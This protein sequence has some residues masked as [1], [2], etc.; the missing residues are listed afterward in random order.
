MPTVEKTFDGQFVWTDLSSD[1]VQESKEFY[2][3]VLDWKF[4]DESIGDEGIYSTGLVDG[5]PAGAIASQEPGQGETKWNVYFQTSDV[6]ATT[7]RVRTAG[8]T[9]VAEP[10]DVF[11]L[12]RMAIYKDP[13]GA[14]FCGWQPK[15]SKGFGVANEH[16]ANGWIELATRD[17]RVKDFY[18]KVFD[19]ELNEI[20]MGPEAKDPY[21]IF[22]KGENFV[23]GMATMTADWGDYPVCW[24]V[25]WDVENVDKAVE[26]AQTKGKVLFPA[27]DTPPGRMAFIADPSGAPCAI[28]TPNPDFDPGI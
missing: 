14:A 27:I 15:E 21:I 26:V 22:K 10:F 5:K 25:Y 13:A 2:A 8:G 9:V 17:H 24:T 20:P 4:E 28:I 11:E 18:A 19:W 12:G 7:E 3:E 6:A 1:R 23:G 16:G